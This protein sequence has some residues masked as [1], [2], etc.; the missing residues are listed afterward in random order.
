M[1]MGWFEYKRWQK[2]ITYKRII[3]TTKLIGLEKELN[4]ETIKIN[5]LKEIRN[6][7][8]KKLG[9]I[10]LEIKEISKKLKTLKTL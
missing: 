7:L 3:S 6:I 10:E 8:D 5:K 4:E 1:E 9:N 2:T